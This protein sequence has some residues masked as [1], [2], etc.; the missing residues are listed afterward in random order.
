MNKE[1]KLIMQQDYEDAFNTK[2]ANG[3]AKFMR[4]QLHIEETKTPK[5]Q[6]LS[7]WYPGNTLDL[8][9][10]LYAFMSPYIKYDN[11]SP[12]EY[13][14]RFMKESFRPLYTDEDG[15]RLPVSQASKNMRMINLFGYSYGASVIQMLS[16]ELTEDMKKAGYSSK[17]IQTIQSEISVLTVGYYANVNNYKNNFSCY[18]LLHIEDRAA[19]DTLSAAIEKKE[20][21]DLEF[22]TSHLRHQPNQKVFMLNGLN[23][24]S[25]QDPHNIKNYFESR[26]PC[27]K[28]TIMNLWKDCILINA[29]NSSVRNAESKVFERLPSDLTILP[30]KIDFVAPEDEGQILSTVF[31]NYQEIEYPH[32]RIKHNDECANIKK[33]K[34]KIRN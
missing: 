21:L 22:Y 4:Q 12:F 28:H 23:L 30:R 8:G 15:Y 19:Y 33:G 17:E 13:V 34:E 27:R 7:A 5:I 29:L 3:L 18:H 24:D 25:T 16:N 9:G 14:R 32:F 20:F 11:D 2:E 10:D 31:D 26:H 1:E 6:V